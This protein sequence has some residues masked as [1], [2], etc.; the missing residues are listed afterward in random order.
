MLA[1]D[2]LGRVVHDGSGREL[3]RVA[4]LIA[5]VGQDG[6]PRVTGVLI[7]PRWRGRLLGYER[8][9]VQGPWLLERLARW[10]HRGTREIPWDEIRWPSA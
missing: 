1:S 9:G 8:P 3:G 2:Y 10:L 4:D 6:V 5:H 7:T